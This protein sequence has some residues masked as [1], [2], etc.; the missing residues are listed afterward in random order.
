MYIRDFP[1]KSTIILF[2]SLP[3]FFP[4]F[5]TLILLSFLSFINSHFI[6]LIMK[7]VSKLSLYGMVFRL[8]WILILWSFS[9]RIAWS[10]IPM[11]KDWQRNTKEDWDDWHDE[12]W[13]GYWSHTFDSISQVQSFP[14]LLSLG[15]CIST[16]S[17]LQCYVMSCHIHV[18]VTMSLWIK[19][20][21]DRCC[22]FGPSSNDE[23]FSYN[24]CTYEGDHLARIWR[25][26]FLS[27][28]SLSNPLIVSNF[29][30]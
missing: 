12:L 14:H 9:M 1:S 25:H 27:P 3:G 18:I 5:T 21:Q 11:I 7:T 2:I 28:F 10:R 26:G 16:P 8:M 29:Y 19:F 23:V 6:P 15:F 20:F 17:N 30:D 24:P 4:F 13:N 22:R